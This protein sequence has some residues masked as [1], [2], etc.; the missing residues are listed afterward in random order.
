MKH[1]QYANI[2]ALQLS[3][4]F[5]QQNHRYKGEKDI[6]SFLLIGKSFHSLEISL[7]KSWFPLQTIIK[8]RFC[9][10]FIFNYCLVTV[11]ES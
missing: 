9:L 7:E 10:F 8:F 3:K 4:L 2:L 11:V 6:A 5:L 1:R